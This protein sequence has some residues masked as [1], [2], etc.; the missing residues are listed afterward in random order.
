VPAAHSNF[1]NIHWTTH[2]TRDND[3]AKDV[4]AFNKT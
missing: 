4:F 3:Q 1:K 2:K